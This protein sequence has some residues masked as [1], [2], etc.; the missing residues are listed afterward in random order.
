MS[1]RVFQGFGDIPPGNWQNCFCFI[2]FYNPKVTCLEYVT[3]CWTLPHSVCVCA[4]LV[5]LR[6]CRPDIL[7]LTGWCPG[8]LRESER[9]VALS[10]CF[11]SR[12]NVKFFLWL[13]NTRTI[14]I[15]QRSDFCFRLCREAETAIIRH[16][17]TLLPVHKYTLHY[18]A[19]F[20]ISRTCVVEWENEG[21]C[22]L[23]GFDAQ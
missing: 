9:D 6:Q 2:K 7:D 20:L 12:E 13:T 8:C 10:R 19:P 11:A 3:V 5:D 14:V 23:A 22:V 1:A 18:K 17:G 4:N 21:N 16:T 15:S